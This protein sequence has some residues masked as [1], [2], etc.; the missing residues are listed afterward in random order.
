MLDLTPS[1]VALASITRK[2]IGQFDLAMF[3]ILYVSGRYAKTSRTS[4]SSYLSIKRAHR[5]P[6]FSSMAEYLSINS[7]CLLIARKNSRNNGVRS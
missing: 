4:N 6:D 2:W 3:E 7:G 1:M 5:A